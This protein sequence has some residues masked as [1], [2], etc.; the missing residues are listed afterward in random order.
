MIVSMSIPKQIGTNFVGGPFRVAGVIDGI[1][2]GG[3]VSPQIVSVPF[4]VGENQVVVVSAR[5]SEDDGRLSDP[6]R[7]QTSV[8]A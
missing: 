7:Q 6:F 8:T 1:D 2:P 5:I 4:P 3:V